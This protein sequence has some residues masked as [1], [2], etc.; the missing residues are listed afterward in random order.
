MARGLARRHGLPHLD[1]DSMT[2]DVP[3]VR[4]P[5]GESN[6]LLES[7]MDEH[8]EWVIE[9]CYADLLQGA[10]SRA[11]ELR[12]LNPGV[13]A[14]VR[15]CRSRPWEPDKYTSSEAQNE[16]LSMLL[17]WVR[18]YETRTDEYSLIRHRALF[19]SF[20]GPKREYVALP[21]LNDE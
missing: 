4:K 11:S 14:C 6:R 16:R 9:G 7:Y 5:L 12:F 18:S 13:E 15:N 10:I 3:A 21:L 8:E 17:S 20:G 2:W 1:L 19:D